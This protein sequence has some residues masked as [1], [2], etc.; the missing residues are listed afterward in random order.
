MTVRVSFSKN[1]DEPEDISLESEP[2]G[3]RLDE[4]LAGQ[5]RRAVERRLSWKRRIFR[6]GKH[7]GLAIYRSCRRK[8][9]A[10]HS[11]G[12]HRFQHV[13]CSKGVLLHVALGMLCPEPYV[14]IRGEVEDD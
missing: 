14:R 10:L 9:D 13:E 3:I 2:F 4:G 8:D 7:G 1:R 12:A 5:F 11:A 6:R